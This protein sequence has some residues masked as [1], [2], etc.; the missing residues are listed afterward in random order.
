MMNDSYD[1]VKI[2]M[3]DVERLKVIYEDKIDKYNMIV[4]KID[5]FNTNI[6]E[7]KIKFE[8]MKVI[9]Q[10][11][12]FRN[13][14]ISINTGILLLLLFISQVLYDMNF[15]DSVAISSLIIFSI[16][17]NT[18]LLSNYN[19]IK[20]LGIDYELEQEKQLIRQLTNYVSE[21]LVLENDIKTE[22]N[23]VWNLYND[24]L[25]KLYTINN[26]MVYT[27]N[28]SKKENLAK[29]RELNLNN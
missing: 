3:E 14:F 28:N 21:L 13:F 8:R 22:I 23:N 19:T 12:Y 29:K 6:M 9:K 1:T 26:E 11:R 27:L 5:K 2:I 18:I 24:S 4:K 25:S 7:L 16:A 17:D 10:I 20:R 15:L